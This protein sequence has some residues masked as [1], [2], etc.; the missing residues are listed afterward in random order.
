MPSGRLPLPRRAAVLTVPVVALLGVTSAAAQEGDGGRASIAVFPIRLD[1]SLPLDDAATAAASAALHEAV[2]KSSGYLT[3]PRT[4]IRRALEE[5]A[6]ETSLAELKAAAAAADQEVVKAR[7]RVEASKEAAEIAPE[8][9]EGRAVHG[10]EEAEEALVAAEAAALAARAKRDQALAAAR[11]RST[12]AACDDACLAGITREVGASKFVRARFAPGEGGC[13]LSAAFHDV[14]LGM[15]ELVLE[16]PGACTAEGASAAVATIA[17]ELA[18]RDAA[19]FAVYERDLEA[20]RAIRNDASAPLASLEVL[21]GAR[22]DPAERI[23]IWLNGAKAGEAVGGR[24][25]GKLAAGRYVLVLKPVS[26]LFTPRRFDLELGPGPS[27]VPPPGAVMLPPVFGGIDFELPAG[28]WRLETGDRALVPSE[29]NPIRPGD[30]PVRLILSDRAL[31]ELTV[32]VRP[33]E[34]TTVRVLERPRTADEMASE[35]GFWTAR[36]WGALALALGAGALGG[37]RMLASHSAADARDTA[38]SGLAGTSDA[39]IYQQLRADAVGHDDDRRTAQIVGLSALGA[40]G[41]F[42]VWSLIEWLWLEPDPGR[43]V[44]PDI[45]VRPLDAIDEAPDAPAAAAPGGAR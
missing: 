20:G 11:A 10:V 33:N 15:F 2:G 40:A 39:V 12:G 22:G 42:A 1:P 8:T 43:L 35:R 37:E 24:W 23:E 27:R 30:I 4:A 14:D 18:A 21:A 17:T 36:K 44:I 13:R 19:G 9:H 31:A 41:G 25:A 28:A 3:V 29:T 5:G 26:P 32:P 6:S 16:A 7:A 45:A 38:L 34:T